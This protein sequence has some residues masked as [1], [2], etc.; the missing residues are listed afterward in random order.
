MPK[1]KG[2]YRPREVRTRY[3]RDI[4]DPGEYPFTRGLYPEMYRARKPTIREFAGHGLA[5]DTNE[6]FRMLLR[7][8]T[9]GLS[10]AFDLPTLMGRDSDDPISEGQVGWDGVAV[11]SLADVEE[12]FG[13]IPIDDISVSMT[14]NAPAAVVWAMYIAM[15]RKRGIPLDRLSGTIQNDILKEYVAQKEWL[16]PEE[17]GVNLVVDTIEFAAGHMPKWHP[18]SISGYHIREAGS[19]AVQEVAYTLAAGAEYVRRTIERGLRVD[20]FAQHLSFFFDLHNNFLEEVAKL[21]AAR[22]L[23]ARMMKERF[24]ATD[25]RSQWCRMHV[26]TAGATLSRNEPLNNL[27]RVALQAMAGMLGGAQ[28]IHTNS[29]D[30]VLCTPTEDAVKLAIRTQQIIQDETG[31]SDFPD[32]LGGSYL[33]EKLT[34]E[35]EAE[36]E[37]EIDRIE[38]MGGMTAAA[39]EGYPQRMIRAAASAYEDAVERGEIVAVGVNKYRTGEV[40][41]PLSV[42]AELETRRG[43]EKAQLKR[44]KKVKQTRDLRSVERALDVVRGAARSGDNM[45]PSLIAAVETYAT[46]GEVCRTLQEVWGEH[47]E[48]EIFGAPPRAV[49]MGDVVRKYRLT[50]PLRILIAKGGLDGHDRI[51]YTLAEFY[52]DLGAEVIYPGLHCSMREIAKRAMEE[53]VDVVGISTHIGSPVVFFERLAEHLREVGK[54]ATLIG[55]GVIRTRELEALESF[56]VKYFSPVGTPFEEIARFLYEEARRRDNGA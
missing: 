13:D 19:T 33:I 28:S 4:G 29:Y 9:A 41:E 46:L 30:E 16:F 8:G 45:M 18:V 22:R 12:L 44:L 3:E 36:A 47:K 35:I 27:I 2:F 15:A 40:D 23:W 51:I 25:P 52:R 43:Y 50:R 24:G 54:E 5:P 17:Q 56:G 53:D 14:I 7:E 32:P 31:V 48:R 55:G 10:T 38:H 11:D 34:G 37:A 1:G 6:R 21:R 49:A 26:Q 39:R 20:D 42:S